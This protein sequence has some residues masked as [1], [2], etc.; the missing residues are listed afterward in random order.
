MKENKTESVRTKQQNKALHKYCQEV[1]DE[2][3][4]SGI[5]MKVLVKDLQVSHTKE[6]V[7]EI[8]RAIAKAKYNKSSTTEMTTKQVTDVFDE[9][10]RM[11][12]NVGVHVAFPSRALFGLEDYSQYYER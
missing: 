9:V 3:N 4:S 11:L 7:K 5:D 10:N 1:A 8:W 6:S 2:L 12:A